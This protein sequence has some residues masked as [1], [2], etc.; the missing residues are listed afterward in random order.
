MA[1]GWIADGRLLD[2]SLYKQ[3]VLDIQMPTHV[4]TEYH[5]HLHLRAHGAPSPPTNVHVRLGM[6]CW[7]LPF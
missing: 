5:I 3:K 2:L 7:L 1:T 4:Y 6:T